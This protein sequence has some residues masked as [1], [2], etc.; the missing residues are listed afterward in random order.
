MFENG[1][2]KFVMD[3]FMNWSSA[4]AMC[5]SEGGFLAYILNSREQSESDY[6]I[7]ISLF[8]KFMSADISCTDLFYSKVSSKIP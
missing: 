7:S 4:D 1:C 6:E 8:I 2:Y 5:Q 3:Q